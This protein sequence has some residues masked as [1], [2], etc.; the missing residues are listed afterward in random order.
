MRL[1]A[2]ER[3]S[4]TV[5]LLLLVAGA[6]LRDR[7]R[8]VPRGARL[9]RH[10]AR[11]LAVHA[12]AGARRRQD[13]LRAHLRRLPGPV[14]PRRGVAGHRHLRLGADALADPGRHP[15]GGDGGG[16]ASSCGGSAAS[17]SGRCRRSSRTWRCGTCTSRRSSRGSS[18]C[19]TSSTTCAV[20]LRGAVR[21]DARARSA[22]VAL[23]N[24][25]V[26]R[27]ALDLLRS[28]CCSSSS[29]SASSAP[30]R[31]A[32]LTGVGV[33]SRI[34]VADRAARGAGRA[35]AGA[36]ASRPSACCWRCYAVGAFALALYCAQSDLS[37]TVLGG[38]PL[39]RDWPKLATALAA[40]WPAVWLLLGAADL[41]ASSATP[42]MAR[43]PRAG[44][45]RAS[46]TRVWSGSAWPARWCSPSRSPTSPPSATRRSTSA[47]SAPPSRARRPRKIV[48]T[49]DQP[50][51]VSLFFPP[52]NE[53]REEVHRLL[54]RS[55][56][57]VEA[58]RGAELRP[59][60]RSAEGQGAGRHRQRHRRV[61]SA[62][63]TASRCRSASSWR[64]ARAQLRNL[65]RDVQK[66]LLKVARPPRNVYSSPAT[67][68]AAFDPVG[69][70]DK[71][72]TVRELREMMQQQGYTVRKLGA[73][74]GLASTCRRTRRWW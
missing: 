69:D 71:R 46:A 61:R 29:A 23:M 11:R 34:G 6:R 41:M 30:A 56:E 63:A 33:R 16:A 24:A 54:R 67:A 44:D 21:V 35:G 47:T 65:D 25:R 49:M 70:T 20:T 45:R 18:T 68:S 1:L 53:V 4:G 55:E 31:R 19:A 26:V 73:A 17:P 51:Q 74:E 38:K 36:I 39:E 14:A 13:Q 8:Q 12:G 50:I 42:T 66:R 57:G 72:G 60:R 40:L 48:A 64:G 3:E 43:A 59:R 58:A 28:A 37:S 2:A 27:L 15:V 52:A 32:A 22:E 5:N 7:P 9:P 62:A 10:P